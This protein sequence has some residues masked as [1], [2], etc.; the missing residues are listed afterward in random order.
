MDDNPRDY[1]AGLRHAVTARIGHLPCHSFPRLGRSDSP[2]LLALGWSVVLAGFALVL[3]V[4][5]WV[6]AGSAQL[7]VSELVGFALVCLGGLLL[8]FSLRGH[9]L[10]QWST[11]SMM[12]P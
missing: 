4:G 1:E 10:L 8:V 12:A 7:P 3:G 9:S 5:D 2:G 6:R 11:E